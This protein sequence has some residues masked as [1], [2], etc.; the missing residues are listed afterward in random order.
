MAGSTSEDVAPPILQN[1]TKKWI[2]NRQTP[3]YTWYF[4]RQLPGDNNGA[5][6]SADLWYWFG[7]LPNCWRPMTQ[8]DYDLSEQMVNYLCNFAKSGNPNGDD[9]PEWLSSQEQKKVLILGEKPT[10]M[11]KPNIF[12]M[13]F[14]MLTNKAVGE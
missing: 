7:T 10:Q 9:L 11:A 5:W 13:I 8:K 3:S 12:K 14:T 2:T 1:M 4:D 6:H